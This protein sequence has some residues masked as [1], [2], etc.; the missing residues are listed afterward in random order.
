MA[1]GAKVQ[2]VTFSFCE[3]WDSDV[4]LAQWAEYDGDALRSLYGKT[5]WPEELRKVLDLP[6][7]EVVVET[8]GGAKRYL[9]RRDGSTTDDDIV[10]RGARGRQPGSGLNVLVRHLRDK[11]GLSY[12]DVLDVLDAAQD[13]RFADQVAAWGEDPKMRLNQLRRAYASARTAHATACPY[14][15]NRLPRRIHDALT[16][17]KSR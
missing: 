8:A 16:R 4:H 14:C 1:Q 6:F 10:P 11:E 15:A 2:R 5:K 17:I 13:P 3:V 7:L 12:G 9:R